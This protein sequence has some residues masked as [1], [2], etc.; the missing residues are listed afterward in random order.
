MIEEQANGDGGGK[1]GG[2]RSRLTRV[3]GIALIAGAVIW[4]QQL[5]E[6]DLLDEGTVA[7]RWD[8]E[9]ADPAGTRLSSEQLAGRAIVLD[10]WST[11]CPPCLKEMAELE[12]LRERFTEEDLAIVGVAAGGETAEEIR[13]FGRRKGVRYPLVV[14]ETAMVGAYRVYTLPTLYIIAPDGRV[15]W[16][17]EG[18]TPFEELAEEVGAA[19]D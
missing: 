8:L 19:L 11:T 1:S 9:R 7:L 18:F 5:L 4:G 2:L 10:F 15:A 14:G 12:R 17:R 3:A 16:A 6:T 13:A